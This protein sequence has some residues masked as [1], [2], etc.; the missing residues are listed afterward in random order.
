MSNLIDRIIS[1]TMEKGIDFMSETMGKGIDKLLSLVFPYAKGTER[2]IELMYEAKAKEDAKKIDAGTHDFNGRELFPLPVANDGHIN[3]IG[4]APLEMLPIT[5]AL[6]SEANNYNTVLSKTA[7]MI[8]SIPDEKISDTGVN[9]DW[10]LRWRREVY[11]ISNVDMQHIWA[12]LLAN[13]IE[14]PGYISL[15]T[16]DVIKNLSSNEVKI[17]TEASNYVILDKGILWNIITR[18]DID[19]LILFNDSALLVD[20]GLLQSLNL[21]GIVKIS[22]FPVSLNLKNFKLNIKYMG[23]NNAPSVDLNCIKLTLAAQEIYKITEPAMPTEEEIKK[24]VSLLYN[25]FPGN[26]QGVTIEVFKRDE[27]GNFSLNPDIIFP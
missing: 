16:L 5:A 23:G 14:S 7:N 17:F 26:S 4:E 12:K 3:S 19:G 13:E 2:Y 24:F 1:S 9:Y 27:C 8:S 18:H 25:A 15:R 21:L 6:Y 20:A 10:F 11:S 22:K